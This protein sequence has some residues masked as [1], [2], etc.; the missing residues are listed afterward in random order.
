MRGAAHRHISS[1]N[2]ECDFIV[3]VHKYEAKTIC[4]VSNNIPYIITSELKEKFTVGEL[5]TF[6]K[7]NGIH[8]YCETDDIIYGNENYICICAVTSG[9]KRNVSELFDGTY[10]GA[11]HGTVELQRGETRL[12]RLD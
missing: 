10:R 4:C 12:F 1:G 5:R 8:I 6:C 3:R 11:T 2:T 7:T 9:K